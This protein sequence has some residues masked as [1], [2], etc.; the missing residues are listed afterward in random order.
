MQ[1]AT[2]LS[3]HLYTCVNCYIAIP[4]QLGRLGVLSREAVQ[5]E[6]VVSFIMALIALTASIQH[7]WITVLDGG[8]DPTVLLENLLQP[9]LLACLQSL[10]VLL[11]ANAPIWHRWKNMQDEFASNCSP[12]MTSLWPKWISLCEQVGR[13]MVDHYYALIQAPTY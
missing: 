5:P 11:D 12:M 3:T 6:S 8:Q 10:A 4:K 1:A 2:F 7:W 9:A 13:G